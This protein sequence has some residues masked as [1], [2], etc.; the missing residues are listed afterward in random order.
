MARPS[1]KDPLD[2]F[3]WTVKIEGF[4]RLGFT[5]CG[6]PSVSYNTRKYPEGGNHLFPKQI[7]DS[8]EYKPVT[9]TR[10]VTA[11]QSFSDWARQA[12]EM[13]RG[14]TEKSTTKQVIPGEVV[15]TYVDA[16]L[17]GTLSN[18]LPQGLRIERIDTSSESSAKIPLEYRRDVVIE[19]RNRQNEIIK[20]YILYNAIPIEYKPAS[21]FESDGDDVL[22][23][24]TLVLAYEGFEVRSVSDNDNNPLDVTDAVKRAI[25]RL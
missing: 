22:S 19:H 8:V 14:R 6:V 1:A 5:S 23:M 15:N 18:G 25:R 2:K 17:G 21:D 20:K 7:I 3:R 12:M 11:D 9:L 10:G 4:T 16:S 24:E 13:F